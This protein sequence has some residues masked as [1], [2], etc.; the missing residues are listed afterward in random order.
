MNI[1]KK[2][3]YGVVAVAAVGT[4]F[5][6]SGCGGTGNAEKTAVGSSNAAKTYIVATRGTA[7]PFSYTDDN[8]KLTGFD[9]EIL[10]EVERRD[11]SLHFEFKSMAMDAAFIALDASQVD[12]IANQ[13][14]RSPAR[15][16]K[17]IFTKEVNNYSVRKLAVKK[18]RNDIHSL[19]DLKGKTI[20]VTTNSEFKQK[21][22]KFNETADPKINVKYTDKGPAETLSLISTDRADAAGEYEY[23]VASA[24][25]DRGLPVKSV[26]DPVQVSPTYFLLRKDPELQKVADKIDKAVKS[27]R[28]DGTLKKIS[29]TF[30]YGDYT[31]EPESTA[32]KG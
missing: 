8:G 2:I 25:K 24:Q 22:E 14:H 19:E 10:R 17:Y 6:V 23:I 29:E 13:A 1:L 32:K 3:L 28:D 5:F 4:A 21:V 7:K 20:V 12:I 26:G 16:K 18:D 11:P 31:V 9:V 15:D 30:L 27:M